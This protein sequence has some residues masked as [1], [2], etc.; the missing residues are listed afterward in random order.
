[1][2]F[3]LELLGL[4]ILTPLAAGV[5]LRLIASTMEFVLEKRETLASIR[6]NT[7]RLLDEERKYRNG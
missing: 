7:A 3:W 2:L 1:M 4:F 5:G 6:R